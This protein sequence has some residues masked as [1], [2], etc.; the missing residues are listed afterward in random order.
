MISHL[1]LPLLLVMGVASCAPADSADAQSSVTT[2]QK[3]ATII[4][5]RHAEKKVGEDP[6]LTAE[7]TARAERLRDMLGEV[8]LA[9]I[10]ATDTR[11]TRATAGPTATAQGIEVM[12]YDPG[13]LD[14]L[15][16]HLRR[17]Y[18]GKT[19]LVVGHSNTTPELLQSLTGSSTTV[20]I[21][22]EDYGNLL[23]ASVPRSGSGT[24]LH[25]HY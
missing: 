9:A 6:D 8:E 11:R 5:V 24:L 22:E 10:Y 20:T 23:V 16:Q 13:A 18:P 17:T 25:L 4:L 21:G 2:R 3:V 1:L 12:S 14:Q 15:A 7:G 19:V